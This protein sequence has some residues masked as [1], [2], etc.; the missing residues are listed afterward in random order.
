MVKCTVMHGIM[1]DVVHG[2]VPGLVHG[3]MHCY[4]RCNAR[5]SAR[6]SASFSAWIVHCSVHGVLSMDVWH[7]RLGQLGFDGL[8]HMIRENMVKGV[9]AL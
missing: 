4:A 6:F 7:L 2:V 3:E 1:H 8:Q 5:C 9:S